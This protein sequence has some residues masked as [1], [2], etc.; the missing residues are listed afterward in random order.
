MKLF[1][2]IISGPSKADGSWDLYASFPSAKGRTNGQLAISID[3]GH[4][5]QIKKIVTANFAYSATQ[6][7]PDGNSL[8]CLYETTGNKE[9]RF[10]T[11]PLTE[12]K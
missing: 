2:S 5:F 8:Y 3:N 10:L 7:S 11:I 12:F 1:T 9:Q 4:T 6:I